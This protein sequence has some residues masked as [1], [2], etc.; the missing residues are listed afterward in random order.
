MN[1][2]PPLTSAASLTEATKLLRR[3]LLVAPKSISVRETLAQACSL[4]STTLLETSDEAD[5]ELKVWDGRIG[6]LAREALQNLEDVAADKM[7]K[8]REL[9][10]YDAAEQ[11]PSMAETFLALSDAAITVSTLAVD[12]ET[13]ELHVEL[14]EQALDQASSMATVSASAKIKSSSSSANLITRVQLASGRSSLERLRHTF[15]L[16]GD[17]DED[18][19]RSLTSEMT[20]LAT[21]CSQRAAK[22]KGTRKAAAATL[23]W[24]AVRQLGDAKLLYANLL[25]LV[26]RRRRPSTWREQRQRRKL[27]AK[28][29]AAEPTITE[30][31]E[32]DAWSTVDGGNEEAG[33]TRRTSAAS[34]SLGA[35][36]HRYGSSLDR[37]A[38]LD[39]LEGF[40][41]LEVGPVGSES[42]FSSAR[43]VSWQP[44]AGADGRSRRLSSMTSPLVGA[45]GINAWTRKSSVISLTIDG[46]DDVVPSTELARSAWELLES[47][48]KQYKSALSLLSISDLPS[49]QLARAKTDTLTTISYASLFMAS[50]APRLSIANEK[51]TS[52]LVTA[53]VYATWAAREVGWSFLIEGTR[54]AQLADRRTNSWRADEAG[55]RAVML[56]VRVWWYRAV[57]MESIDA[58]TKIAAKDAVEVVV[59]RMKDREGVR[60]G[61]VVRFRAW[62]GKY[63]GELD[64]AEELFWR[65]V[66][67][68][69]RGGEGFVLS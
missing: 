21:E 35:P 45:D 41:R 28:S 34:A 13:I 19:F 20:M 57:T 61:D 53:E 25:R 62:L 2:Q 42:S 43:R 56:L 54:E 10:Q 39:P 69:L 18:D 7:D 32:E 14:S 59:R 55:K 23:G 29:D 51:R 63:E 33:R 6:H 49:A 15:I 40:N 9:R 66:S 3:I 38:D 12:L 52:L 30:E 67:R 64:A 65:S 50:L 60:F 16:G 47:A 17:L 68:I 37:V 27:S 44:T 58:Q 5:D 24:E 31:D 26:W 46:E 4:L 22:L 11:A 1:Y 36:I 8:L 48:I